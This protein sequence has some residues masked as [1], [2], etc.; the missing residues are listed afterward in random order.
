MDR[1]LTAVSL[2]IRRAVVEELAG[3]GSIC[4]H[5]LLQQRRSRPLPTRVGGKGLPRV[6]IGVQRVIAI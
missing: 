5:V 6:R 1:Y 3:P 2:Q 4:T